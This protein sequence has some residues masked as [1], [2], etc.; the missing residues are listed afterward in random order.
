MASFSKQEFERMIQASK[1]LGLDRNKWR[2]NDA[3]KLH[4]DE[5]MTHTVSLKATPHYFVEKEY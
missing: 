4:E 2:F 3:L 1:V 5:A